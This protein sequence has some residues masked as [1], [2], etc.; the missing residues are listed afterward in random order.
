[1]S[2]KIKT[3][4][5]TMITLLVMG[6]GVFL[7]SQDILLAHF[8]Q[9]ERTIHY[10]DVSQIVKS[11]DRIYSEIGS[12]AVD[13]AYWDS[14]DAYLRGQ[15]PAFP[16]ENLMP[17]VY[18]SLGIDLVALG[19]VDGKVLFAE[20]Y[21]RTSGKVNQAT[22]V[23][24]PL[25][26]P[27]T[28]FWKTLS[29]SGA[30]NSFV[31]IDGRSYFVTARKV[32]PTSATGDSAGFLVF[33]RA[34]DENVL[35]TLRVETGIETISYYPI[36]SL[37]EELRPYLSQLKEDQSL[38][39][40]SSSED[41][42][43][44]IV[45]LRGLDGEL[46][47][48]LVSQMARD[49]YREGQVATRYLLY[50]LILIG[51][52]ALLAN[53]LV[54]NYM[55][56]RPLEI[57]AGRVREAGNLQEQIQVL[58][59]NPIEL[60]TLNE[61]LQTVLQKAQEAHQES[62]N[63]QELYTHLFEQ[64]REGF[65]IL[66]GQGLT[67]LEGNEVFTR[68]LGWN[69]SQSESVTLI[70]L[71]SGMVNEETLSRVRSVIGKVAEENASE[72]SIEVWLKG[73]GQVFD[74]S[75]SPIQIEGN[76]FFYVLLRDIRER[77][78]LEQ[79]LKDRLRET[80]LLNQIVAVTTS[81]LEP[82][83]VF[84]TVC[85]E[86]AV[87][88][89]LPQSA[90]ALLNESR[91]ALEIV[92]EYSS[93][94]IPSIIGKVISLNDRLFELATS[95]AEPYQVHP[96][97]E[98][99][100]S[101]AF[102]P[103]LESRGTRS[104][105]LVPL[106]VREEVIG[107]LGL[108]DRRERVFSPEEIRLAQSMALAA[109]RAFEVTSL[110]HDL[111]REL[112][113]R[114]QAEEDLDRRKRYLEALVQVLFDLLSLE[115][116]AGLYDIVLPMLGETTRADRV[117]VFELFQS[118]DRG[119]YFRR[120]GGWVSG[121]SGDHLSFTPQENLLL[122][123]E[124]MDILPELEKGQPVARLTEDLPPAL[125]ERLEAH[126]FRS[127]FILPMFFK[128]QLGGIILFDSFEE[129]I[130]GDALEVALL[131]VAVAS[132]AMT[133]ERIQVNEA[134]RASEGHYRL[135]VENARDVIFQI[136][137]T[138]R[139][140][141]LNPAW[142]TVT[143]LK[144]E[145]AI[146]LP[147]WKVV[148]EGMLREL[149]AGFRILR[150]K[151][152]DRYH[153]TITISNIYGKTVWLDMHIRLVPDVSGEGEM[154][155]GT[156]VDITSYKRMEYILRRNEEALRSLYDI[157]SSLSLSMENKLDHLLRLGTQT[158]DMERGY[159]GQVQGDVVFLRNVYPP[160]DEAIKQRVDIQRTFARETLRANEPVGIE[161]VASSD[162][163]DHEAFVS[164]RIQSFIGTPVLV[165]KE[166]YGVIAFYS[167]QPRQ[168]SFSLAD[169]EFIR[170]MAQWIGS[171]FERERYTAQLRAYNEEIAQKSLELAEARDQA[172]EASRLK[173]EFLATM[174]HEI[175]TP[176]NAVIGMAELLME[177]HLDDEQS[178]F[179][180]IIRDSGRGLLGIINDILDF[181]KIEAG[182]MSLEMVPFEL[183]PLV[184]GVLEMFAQAAQEKKIGL[185]GY[186][187]PEIPSILIGD[188][189]RLRQILTNL[190]SNGVKFTENG[191]VVV[192]VDLVSREDGHVR[193][194]F[195]VSDT[196]IGLSEVARRRLFT[197]FTQAD[198]STTRKYG[199]TGLGLVISK[200]L[201][202]LMGGEI[203]VKSVEG[204]GSVF[205]FT[206]GLHTSSEPTTPSRQ[207]QA[208]MRGVHCLIL[209]E[210][211][212]LRRILCAFLRS[213][214]IGRIVEIWDN[215]TLEKT[216][217]IEG[218]GHEGS[219]FL[220]CDLDSENLHLEEP[221]LTFRRQAPQNRVF[222][223]YLAG[224][225]KRDQAERLAAY[226]GAAYLLKPIKQSA[227]TGL[228]VEVFGEGQG[229]KPAVPQPVEKE[230]R[231]E[232]A[233]V[234]STV[235]QIGEGVILLAEDNPANQRLATVQLKRLGYEVD[236][237]TNGAQALEAYELYPDRYAVILMDCQMPVMDGFE[238]T[239]RI[240]VLEEATHRHIPIVAM[241]ANAMQGDR[242]ACLAAGMDDYISKPVSLDSLR[243]ILSQLCEAV[244]TK[245]GNLP[246]LQ[247]E[248][249]VSYNPIDP[250][251][252]QG[253]RELQE[254]DEPDFLTELID[255]Y[256]EDA[257]VLVSEIEEKTRSGD[258]GGVR[259]AAHT[260]KGSSG[261][262][263]ALVLSKICYEME[264]CAK[265][266]DLAG[267]QKVL[268]RLVEE[269]EMVTTQLRKERKI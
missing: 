243:N 61:P 79:S 3:S 251:V 261:N 72:Q 93:Q 91:S 213:Q 220:I 83:T 104:A 154:I 54:S 87:N 66:D 170:L 78:Q 231:A 258:L 183:L 263:G 9:L 163:A 5:L 201:V 212:A 207:Y 204:V 112:E 42:L 180:R 125:K 106:I 171:E 131:Q 177:T 132:M 217:Q 185:M 253:L 58:A 121:A 26:M 62:R 175:R 214:G 36:S 265:N 10:K 209:S 65:A 111:Q 246:G 199:G 259:Q 21:D 120:M 151:V 126:G 7:M 149:G 140:T 12:L 8:A 150:E 94:T 50:G 184:E 155:A 195:K 1:M 228:L 257:A 22:A 128:D 237:V 141:F 20:R 98:S 208:G 31:Q 192:R 13:W 174:S 216:L 260:L 117:S 187:S 142:E 235:I 202:E 70:D 68:M 169:K 211:P 244:S 69:R 156:M 222:I 234:E 198:G 113:K 119:P 127:A 221:I 84:A 158:F 110:Y 159:L 28:A 116:S 74:V 39:L 23:I 215:L 40:D 115:N 223:L 190:V 144:V 254:E 64:A 252:I 19:G 218:D 147:F 89:G 95:H 189:L 193:L 166:L 186:V 255:I 182:R 47:G 37:P 266:G 46:T 103:I 248:K 200:R 6:A 124:L 77:K 123:G 136:D 153:Q 203:D 152:T 99:A 48:L 179:V 205:Q 148:P 57:L 130:T 35:D 90:L 102:R 11:V 100:F 236:L 242:E 55:L 206:I 167:S 233:S 16:E 181:S 88:L 164:N 53:L 30:A 34:L 145:D 196:G 225:S 238:A 245:T 18:S 264:L 232:V 63:R 230:V 224:F 92:A 176:L 71:L 138:G 188:P 43:L 107:W 194:R 129:K 67:I 219:H 29:E 33:G 241:T 165:G 268:P 137:L 24:E 56:F 114:Q 157:T 109:S 44:G 267:A 162:W 262:L 191:E 52:V 139:F 25:F 27:E 229:Q 118:A 226:P 41:S 247:S 250:S 249:T 173:S 240:R 105:L 161:N 51:A 197:P 86:L 256:L 60:E 96:G 101:R 75:F 239:R 210:D 172:L 227:F 38:F 135:V 2:V 45:P 76:R 146:G 134:M 108:E 32:Y 122:S 15:N 81:N 168:G 17:A 178:D 269:F 133:R 80:T 14:T 59:Q 160:D 85:R 4:L 97:E 49:V 73:G 82:I 143:G